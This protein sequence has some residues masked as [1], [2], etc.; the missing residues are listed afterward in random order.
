ML[1]LDHTSSLGPSIMRIAIAIKSA[2]WRHLQN[3]NAIS[4]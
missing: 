2:K 1:T 4:K 3:H